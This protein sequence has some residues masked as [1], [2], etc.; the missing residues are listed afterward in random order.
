MQ[1]LQASEVFSSVGVGKFIWLA[2][3]GDMAKGLPVLDG[4]DAIGRPH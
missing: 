2:E 1:Y 3:G 4:D